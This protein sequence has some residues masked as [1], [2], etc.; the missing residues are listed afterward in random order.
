[1]MRRE[2]YINK[3]DMSLMYFVAN[4]RGSFIAMF[5]QKWMAEKFI[6]ENAFEHDF[7]LVTE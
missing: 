6:E 1:M 7:H 4:E 2:D 5:R 3:I